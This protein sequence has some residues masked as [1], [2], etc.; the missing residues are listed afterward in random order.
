MRE[1]DI[2][3][4]PGDGIGK[5]VVPAKRLHEAMQY[6]AAHILDAP[7][8]L[9]PAV[10]VN[11]VGVNA[12]SDNNKRQET[13]LQRL[14]AASMLNN[15]YNMG[16]EDARSYQLNDYLD[17]LFSAVWR[18]LTDAS[19][20]KNKAR[21]SLQRNYVSLLNRLL[22]PADADLKSGNTQQDFESD[23]VLYVEQ[24]LSRVEQFCQEQAAVQ[25]GTRPSINA[26]HYQDLLRQIK[27]IRERRTTI[28]RN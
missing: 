28:H 22:N 19:E 17:D 3:K 27:L 10:I 12:T 20:W 14:L 6:V 8:W 16:T 13:T 11:K 1:Y 7:E 4:I 5:E 23:A 18:P 21:R 26:L 2:A 9:Y 15:I 24:H 25:T